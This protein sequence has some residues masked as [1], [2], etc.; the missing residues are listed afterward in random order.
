MRYL[1]KVHDFLVDYIVEPIACT[2]RALYLI[3]IFAPVVLAVPVAFVGGRVKERHNE[4]RG[5]LLW[6]KLLVK[7]MESAG[8]AFIKLGQWA[9]SRTDIFPTELCALMGVLHSNA[10]AHAFEETKR[11]IEAAFGTDS[12][13]DIFEYFDKEPLGTGA[14]A[15]VYRGKLREGISPPSFDEEEM[16]FRR[17]LK[18]TV[19]KLVKRAPAKVPNKEVAIKVLHPN[20]DR[21]VHRDLRIMNFFAQV[22][23]LIPTVEWLSLPDE[24]LRFGEMMRLQLDLR[25]EANNLATFRHKFKDRTTVYFP[26]PYT[27]YST[28]E[29]LVEEYAHG[30]PLEAFLENGGGSFQKDIADM[31]L[32]AF[33]VSFS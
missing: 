2:F 24:V 19:D 3:A 7:A 23:N 17:E 4:R 12:F 29:V 16:D 15:Q 21:L 25:I 32:D 31:G 8:P 33:L 18:M 30:V 28:R 14:I 27:E 10:P 26:I 6:Y 9:A 1:A 22:L 11:I 5:T 20:V 13:E